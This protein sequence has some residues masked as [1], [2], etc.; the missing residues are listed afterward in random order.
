LLAACDVASS[1]T[2]GIED[3]PLRAGVYGAFIATVE[4]TM[5]TVFHCRLIPL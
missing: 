3:L 2:Y 5:G 4:A 1:A